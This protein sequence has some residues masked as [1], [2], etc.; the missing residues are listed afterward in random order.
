V[1]GSAELVWAR[2]TTWEGINDELFPVLKMTWPRGLREDTKLVDATAGQR[3]G[4]S[5]LLLGRVFPVDF[6]DIC[7]QSIGPGFCFVERSRMLWL[8]RWRHERV[9]SSVPGGALITDTLTWRRRGLLRFV[10]CSGWLIRHIVSM[11][12]RHRH[13]RLRRRWS[14]R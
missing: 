7:I 3:L 1:S 9:V 14:S 12:F 10:P 5:W 6:D 13:R 4:R 11:L 2:A 8:T